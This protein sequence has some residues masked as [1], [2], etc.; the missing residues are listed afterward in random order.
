[1]RYIVCDDCGGYYKLENEESLEDFDKCQCGGNLRYAQS[2]KEIIRN[3]DA[4]TIRCMHCGAENKETETYCSNCGEKLGKIRRRVSDQAKIHD[5]KRKTQKTTSH[6]NIMDRISFTGLF[7]GVVFLVISTIIAVFGMMGSIV[8]SDGVN[9]LRSLGGYLIIMIFVIIASGFISSYISGVKEY[10]DGF[11]NGSLVGLA[12]SLLAAI[13]VTLAGM[14]ISV[15]TGIIAG[16]I[17]LVAYG[18]I[19]GV[20]TGVGGLVAVWLR[21]YME[22]Y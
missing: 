21:N 8:A 12:L 11:L 15:G 14:T 19:Y 3:R 4:P 22:D 6:V 17:T 13:F 1:M 2:F 10:V 5:Q 9:L 20:L 18:L 7:A 16:L